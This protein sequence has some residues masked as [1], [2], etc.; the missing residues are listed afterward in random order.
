MGELRTNPSLGLLPLLIA[1]SATLLYTI[2]PKPKLKPLIQVQSYT[3][4]GRGGGLHHIKTILI[5]T[6]EDIFLGLAYKLLIIGKPRI[7]SARMREVRF[8]FLR[9]WISHLETLVGRAALDLLVSSS[10]D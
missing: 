5:S 2:R 7:Q 1:G 9:W 6:R 3:L 4:R 8:L 10:V